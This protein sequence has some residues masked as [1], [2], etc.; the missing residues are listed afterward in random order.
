MHGIEITF[1]VKLISLTKLNNLFREIDFRQVS[2]R[3]LIGGA[4]VPSVIQMIFSK[5]K[6]NGHWHM[7]R[8]LKMFVI[9]SVDFPQPNCGSQIRYAKN[10][11]KKIFEISLYSIIFNPFR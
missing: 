6:K 8:S 4:P 7:E 10:N 9:D 1:F 3:A 5:R 11:V 2:K